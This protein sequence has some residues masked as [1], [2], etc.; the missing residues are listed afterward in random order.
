MPDV[1]AEFLLLS[2]N[3][4]A[5]RICTDFAHPDS[6]KSFQVPCA[7]DGHYKRFLKLKPG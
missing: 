4:A 2:G 6:M 5:A 3:G 1:P 7:N